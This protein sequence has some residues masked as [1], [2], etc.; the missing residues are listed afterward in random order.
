MSKIPYKVLALFDEMIEINSLKNAKLKEKK[1]EEN[2]KIFKEIINTIYSYGSKESIKIVS[3]MQKENYEAAVKRIT[4]NEYRMMAIYVL[5]ATQI[6]Y[7]VT[8]AVISPKYWFIMKLNDFDSQ[9]KRIS[10]ATNKLIDELGL[11]KNFMM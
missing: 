9:E 10:E 6:K 3:L 11:D 5:L 1:Q 4:Q 2:L 7:D 8:S